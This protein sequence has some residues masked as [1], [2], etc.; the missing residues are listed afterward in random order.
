M[1]VEDALRWGWAAIGAS[2]A[3]GMTRAA[4][5]SRARQVQLARDAGALAQ[6]PLHLASLAL[7]TSWTGD[8]AGAASLIAEAESV[9][10]ATGTAFAPLHLD[11]ARGTAGREVEA[12]ALIAEHDRA[13][14]LRRSRDRLRRTR[15]GARR[16]CTTASAATR[17]RHRAA[18]Q[19]ASNTFKPWRIHVGRCPSWSRRPSARATPSWPAMHSSGWRRR[20]SPAG[21][22]WALGIEARCRALLSDGDRCRRVCI[23]RRSSG[24]A[25]PGCV[26]ARPR[27]PALRR[28]AAPRESPG[29]RARATAR[30]PRDVAA[31]GME[32]F[33]ERAR[34][35]LRRRARRCAS[36]RSRRATI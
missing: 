29:R 19:A 11:E 34:N 36:G 25:A 12:A 33:A 5:R 16:S 21:T 23:A 15:M 4:Q 26:R 17:R 35:E 30:G 8:F 18:R 2:T 7:S 1:P 31:I 10:A 32:A 22:D 6:L 3:C 27:P 24:W 14:Q 28:V 20:H 13:R 9:A